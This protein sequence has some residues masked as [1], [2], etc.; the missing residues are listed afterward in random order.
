MMSSQSMFVVRLAQPTC[1]TNT[2]SETPAKAKTDRKDPPAEFLW[3]NAQEENP[4][5]RAAS[6]EKQSFIRARHH[7]LKKEARMQSLQTSMEPLPA[8][9]DH[10]PAEAADYHRSS[11]VDCQD[12]GY[13]SS[14]NPQ[15]PVIYQS[16]E[17][18][19]S[20]AFPFLSRPT[21]QSMTIYLKHYQVHA[22]K[23]CFPLGDKQITFRYLRTALN[24][25]AL[26]QILLST[27]AFHRA[28]V[29]SVTGAPSQMVRTS[30]Q[31]AIRLRSETIKSLQAILIKP[32]EFYSEATL[33]AAEANVEAVRAHEK[34]IK[35]IVDALGGLNNLGYDAISILYV[36]DLM[37]GLIN[38]YP[39]QLNKSWKWEFKVRKDC[40]FLWELC[41]TETP[42]FVG[43]RFF[44]SSWSSGLHPQLRSTLRSLQQLVSFY[45][46]VGAS[47][48]EQTRMD[49]DGLLLLNHELL[50][51]A[52]DHSLPA[53]QDTLRLAV[54]VYTVVRIRGFAGM[55]CAGIFVRNLRRSLQKGILSLE[56]TAPDLLMWM[57]FI[58]S[59]ASG[60][61][62]CHSWFLAQ[63]Q[64]TAGRLSLEKW[65][66]ALVVLQEF[67]FVC[68]PSDGP[69][70]ELWKSAF[71]E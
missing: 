3:I 24:H 16:L 50:S 69:V 65:D 53:F 19:I 44:N 37:R 13:E 48:R 57:L 63:L 11:D 45:E 1:P 25:P 30:T 14:V 56:S 40:F 23:L 15:S 51:L 55:P 71:Q 61:R 33:R 52:H 35:K 47:S 62:D 32:Y 54:L 64:Q 8:D 20:M 2:R 4:R 12:S 34:A 46:N 68:R 18:C 21:N 38:D 58:G 70:K 42:P 31:D 66:D 5:D 39:V 28:T 49:N 6:R 43:R 36:C 22:T 41:Q 9:G 26:V 60:G 29:H 59:L 27:S 17:A 67:F 10:P 7:R